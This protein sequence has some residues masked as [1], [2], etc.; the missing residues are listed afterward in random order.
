MKCHEY[1]Y[2]LKWLMC[3]K[4]TMQIPVLRTKELRGVPL[5]HNCEILTFNWFN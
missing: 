3:N 4:G 2:G 5:L 1:D